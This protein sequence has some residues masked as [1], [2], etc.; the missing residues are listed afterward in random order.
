MPAFTVWPDD[1]VPHS[2][3]CFVFANTEKQKDAAR[4]FGGQAGFLAALPRNG[5]I[6]LPSRSQDQL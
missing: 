2:A 1:P 3:D 4:K 5:R 6:I